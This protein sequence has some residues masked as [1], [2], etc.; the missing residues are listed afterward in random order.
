MNASAPI[1]FVCAM[2]MELRPLKKQLGLSSKSFGDISI[3]AGELDG[4]PVVAHVTGMG[5][6]LATDGT[7]ALLD[8][9]SPSRVVVFG[10]T[11]A[12]TDETQLGTLAFPELVIDAATG[13]EHRHE[14][15]GPGEPRGVMWTTDVITTAAELP[16]LLERGVIA[17]DMETASIAHACEQRGVPWCVIRAYSD[18]ATDGSVDDELF[19][20]SK[21]DGTP[22]PKAV[23]K[24][25][26]RHPGKIPQLARMGAAANKAATLAASS[27][28]AAVRAATP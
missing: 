26:L 10:I 2:P 6:K 13:R 22:D 24:Y 20:L 9:V 15:L 21:Q 7:T 17:L 23:V 5:T 18:R 3:L 1:A 11:G 14:P 8:A 25:V 28:I 27:A 19:H 16:A 12:V 4:R